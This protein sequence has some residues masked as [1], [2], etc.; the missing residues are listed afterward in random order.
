MPEFHTLNKECYGSCAK[1]TLNGLYSITPMVGSVWCT[2]TPQLLQCAITFTRW[3]AV[4]PF[5]GYQTSK[6]HWKGRSKQSYSV[7]NE[8]TKVLT[9]SA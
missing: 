5:T 9:L 7:L 3:L 1:H 6:W 4:P 8:R 2:C